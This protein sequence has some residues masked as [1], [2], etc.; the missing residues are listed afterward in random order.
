MNNNIHTDYIQDL[1][2]FIRTSPTSFHAVQ[3]I[4]ELL[5]GN[6]FIELKEDESWQLEP[7]GAYFVRRNSSS[8][9]LFTLSRDAPDS[10]LRMAGAHTD[11]PSL[12]I[13]PKP[14]MVNHGYVQMGVETYGGS[15]L[16]SW[17]DRDLS[18]AG[19]VIWS[20]ADNSIHSS[21][22][23][24]MTPVGIIPSLA[25]HLDRE[26]NEKKSVNKQKDLVPIVMQAADDGKPDLQDILRDYLQESNPLSTNPQILDH[27]LFFYDCQPPALVGM[28]SEFITGARLDNLLSCYTLVRALS[29][30]PI[31]QN[32]LIV[33]N[34][35]EE[36]GSMSSSGAQG[37]FMQSVL[38]RIIPEYEL[39]QRCLSRSIFISADNAH[40]VHPNFA[41]SHD[42][43]H[44]PLLNG[45]PVIKFN[46]NQRY[47]TNSRTSSFF[48]LL[49]RKADVPVQE[50]VMRNDLACGSTIGPLTAGKTGVQTI[51][52][53]L[54]SFAMHSIRETA[55]SSDVTCFLEVFRHFF[56]TRPDDPIW[57]TV[58]G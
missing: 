24:F 44:L 47:A 14:L 55:G 1:L 25:I 8:M 54:P 2:T 38:E 49:C 42:N 12:K 31:R 18:I 50:F 29:E 28:K 5:T 35:H 19:R 37:N 56:A 16:N 36:T 45:G 9:I 58:L 6:G 11:S 41:D 57:Q 48:R 39:R 43:K 30:S 23:D 40:G 15:L 33:L 26:A 21:L 10:G 32:S 34:D 17:F 22:I 13:K 20:D 53:G 27:E 3:N 7:A 4:S 46:A 52:V 51:D